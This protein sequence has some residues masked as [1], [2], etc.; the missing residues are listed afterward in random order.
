MAEAKD[1]QKATA[2]RIVE[3]FKNGRSRV[4]LADEVGLGKTIVAHS[5]IDGYRQYRKGRDDFYK[6][7]YICSNANV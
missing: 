4:L 2:E 6:V 5:V 3:L 7:V 1:F